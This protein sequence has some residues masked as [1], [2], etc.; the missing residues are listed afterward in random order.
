MEKK[1]SGIETVAEGFVSDIESDLELEALK[2]VPEEVIQGLKPKI[3]NA[4]E[5]VVSWRIGYQNPKGLFARMKDYIFG[6][7]YKGDE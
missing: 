5:R 1:N 7:N 4:S 3:K 2:D 6:S